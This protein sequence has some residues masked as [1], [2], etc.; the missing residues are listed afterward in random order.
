MIASVLDALQWAFVLYFVAI[1]S[2]YLALNVIAFVAAWRH[3]QDQVLAELPQT[4]SNLEVPISLIVPAYNEHATIAT[5]IRSLLQLSYAEFEIVVVN[6]GS[7]D[8]TLAELRREFELVQV[9]L[10]FRL[11]L[12][13]KPIRAVYQSLRHP[14]LR[15]IDKDNGGKADALNAG[16]NASRFPLFCALDAD[17]VLERDSLKRVVRP[18]LEDARTV[19]AGGIIRLAN[20][21]EVSDGL[22]VRT[23]L[24][25]NPLALMQVVEYLRAFLFGR[26]GWSPL[27]G[28]LVISGAFGLF[29]K[30]VVVAVGG[31]RADTLG[32]DMELVVRLHRVLR[33]RNQ[34]YLITFVPDPVCWTEA[35]ESWRVL[36]KQRARW[37]RGLAESLRMN[38]SLL[39]ARRGGVPGWLSFPFALI[40]EFASP[41]VEIAGYVYFSVGLIFGFASLQFAAAFAL[42]AVGLGVLLSV[43]AVLLEE[44]SF[45][46]YP[47]VSDVMKL[48]LAGVIE[49]FGYRQAIALWRLTGLWAWIT[50]QQARWGDMPRTAT[51]QRKAVDA[52]QPTS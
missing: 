18:F 51:W 40:F 48:L 35:P 14:E 21:C 43:C 2:A 45:H 8:S 11:R 50:G 22:L 6:D 12:G 49:N 1:S 13:S 38:S 20:G 31:Y 24:P 29:Q 36:G 23:G 37:Q 34:P 10:A 46:T 32:E 15:V 27:N 47:R 4:F 30:D 41:V 42:L 44:I 25:K 16:L 19:A 17:S 9:P 39:F 5:S 33:E 7:K 26:L 52:R 3:R 28:V